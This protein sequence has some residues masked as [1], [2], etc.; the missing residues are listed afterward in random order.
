MKQDVA[1][2]VRLLDRRELTSWSERAKAFVLTRGGQV[3]DPGEHL[4][5]RCERILV[6]SDLQLSDDRRPIVTV[7]KE[8]V[9]RRCR[10]AMTLRR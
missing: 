8:Q 6:G 7:R 3:S 4:N 5:E 1:V 10:Y 2:E 9:D